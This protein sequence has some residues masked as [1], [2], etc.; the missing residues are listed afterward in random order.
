MIK[1]QCVI[2][3]LPWSN[4]MRKTTKGELSERAINTMANSAYILRSLVSRALGIRAESVILS[5]EIEATRSFTGRD[6]WSQQSDKCSFK[7]WGFSPTRGFTDLNEYVGCI[8]NSTSGEN[9]GNE[10]TQL[11]HIPNVEE[12]VFFVVNEIFTSGNG[13]DYDNLSWTLYKA[14][15]FAQKWAKIENSDVLRWSEWLL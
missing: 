9:Q 3:S 13:S 14:P 15:N 10:G 2:N 8:R 7:L 1:M 5:G 6:C 12:F 11:L 4:D